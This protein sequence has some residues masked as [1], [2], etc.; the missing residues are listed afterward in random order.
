MVRSRSVA[1][2]PAVVTPRATLPAH[3]HSKASHGR[4]AACTAARVAPAGDGTGVRTADGV[5]ADLARRFEKLPR[6]STASMAAGG[7]R[8]AVARWATMDTACAPR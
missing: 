7:R 3:D 4:H 6:C 1:K 2:A 8:F 5:A